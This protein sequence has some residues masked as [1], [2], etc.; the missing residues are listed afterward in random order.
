MYYVN[1]TIRGHVRRRDLVLIVFAGNENLWLREIHSNRTLPIAEI[2]AETVAN[3][4]VSGWIGGFGIPSTITTGRGT[5]FKSH[6]WQQLM[7]IL[8]THRIRTTAYHSMSNG[9]I[10]GFHHTLNAALQDHGQHTSWINTL[11]LVLLGI[12]A[13]VKEDLGCSAAE[14]VNDS[15]LHLPGQFFLPSPDAIIQLTFHNLNLQ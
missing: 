1:V 5:Q 7:K 3:A 10:E 11:P 8:G 13:A 6:L 4:F 12:R 2:T 9:I 14:L 15:P